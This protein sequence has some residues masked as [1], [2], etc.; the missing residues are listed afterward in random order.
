MDEPVVHCTSSQILG[1]NWTG[2]F[3]GA[4]KI[5]RGGLGRRGA[6]FG[7]RYPNPLFIYITQKQKKLFYT[8]FCKNKLLGN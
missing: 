4:P 7:N 3:R 6:H 2:M 1:S 8:L 5:F